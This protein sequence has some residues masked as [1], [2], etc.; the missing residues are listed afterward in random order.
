MKFLSLSRLIVP[1]SL[2]LIVAAVACTQ[3][4]GE[5]STP[6]P[7]PPA[8]P[9]EAPRPL[10][11][12]ERAAIG[13]FEA[14]LQSI[15]D[16]WESFYE[17]FDAWRLGLVECHPSTAREALQELSA[18]FAPIAAK[19]RNLTR[20]P[21]TSELADLVIAATDAEESAFRQLRD[22]WKAGNITLFEQV[23]QQRTESALAHNSA[24]DMSLVL[25]QELEDGPTLDQIDEMKAFATAFDALA[26]DWDDF[27]D[28]YAA[29]AKRESKLEME[30]RTIGY[31]ELVAQLNA[32]LTTVNGLQTGEINEDIV[33][34]LQEAIEDEVGALQFLADFP[35][36]L[37]EE[38]AGA[39]EE[40]APTA[41]AMQ[42]TAPATGPGSRPGSRA[43]YNA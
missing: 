15:D 16:E 5:S 39:P 28:A 33:D 1:I 13:E 4:G 2:V 21:G 12:D 6:F 18:S 20:T 37:T 10:T 29:F 3:G 43:S 8:A 35:P 26:D 40:S 38:A 30:D 22:R 11:A 9:T 25:Q 7:I 41:T 24:A 27:H 32:I 23:E 19:A 42:A 17:D 14:Q 34:A 36:D 31:F